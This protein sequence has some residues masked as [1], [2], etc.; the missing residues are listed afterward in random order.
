MCQLRAQFPRMSISFCRLWHACCWLSTVL[1]NLVS[2]A[3]FK[4][5][6]DRMV[7]Q[8]VD[9]DEEEN[10]TQNRS[11]RDPTGIPSKQ[12]GCHLSDNHAFRP[13]QLISKPSTPCASNLVRSLWWGTVNQNI[14]Y[15]HYAAHQY[16]QLQ[17][18]G[19]L[20]DSK[21]TNSLYEN[22]VVNSWSN[23]AGPSGALMHLCSLRTNRF[24][25]LAKAYIKVIQRSFGIT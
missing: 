8:I 2:S 19:K 25:Y 24:H 11:L 17:I 16:L 18:Q 23:Y 13:I 7:I 12:T 1:N 5:V 4:T 3:N 20:E 9:K 15:P 22:H 10:R 21:H 6:A 14:Q